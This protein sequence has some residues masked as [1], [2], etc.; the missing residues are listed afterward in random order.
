MQGNRDLMCWEWEKYSYNSMRESK[1]RNQAFSN[2]SIS[3]FKNIPVLLRGQ[4]CLFSF[5][6]FVTSLKCVFLV[7]IL[8]NFVMLSLQS[9]RSWKSNTEIKN[10]TGLDVAIEV[11]VFRSSV[12]WPSRKFGMVDIGSWKLALGNNL[13]NNNNDNKIK[14]WGSNWKF[15]SFT[16]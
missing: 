14:K 8:A 16:F 5:N 11:L 3:I 15:I 4:G 10:K 12:T 13:Q 7:S 9:V 2:N 6:V 1:G